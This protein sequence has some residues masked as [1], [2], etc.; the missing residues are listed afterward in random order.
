[1]AG[2]DEIARAAVERDVEFR[3]RKARALHDRLV[4]A[5][6]ETFRSPSLVIRTGRKLSS[7]KARA[8]RRIGMDGAHRGGAPAE[9]PQRPCD[10]P[11]VARRLALRNG[12]Q[13]V[14]KAAKAAL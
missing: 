4:V 13:L 12:W 2:G 1:M 8:A 5:G 7:K 3:T 9:L 14:W 6:Q 10:R 11:Q